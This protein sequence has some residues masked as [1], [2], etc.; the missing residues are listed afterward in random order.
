MATGAVALGIKRPGREADH[1]PPSSIEVKKNAW[2]YTSIFPTRVHSVYLAKHR[3]EFTFAF[4][5]YRELG[6]KAK[7]FVLV[8]QTP[9]KRI[10]L[11][12]ISGTFLNIV[13]LS[14]RI[15]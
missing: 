6:Y 1:S 9:F 15:Y 4:K 2:T 13:W 12:H 8:V 5:I 11:Y 14:V 7:P 10:A 3:N